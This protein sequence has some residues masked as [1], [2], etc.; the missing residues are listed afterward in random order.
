MSEHGKIQSKFQRIESWSRG[1]GAVKLFAHGEVTAIRRVVLVVEFVADQLGAQFR[2][3]T[4]ALKRLDDRLSQRVEASLTRG[5]VL[6][7]LFQMAPEGFRDPVALPILRV[8]LGGGKQAL[9][10][11]GTKPVDP[12]P[13]AQRQQVWVDWHGPKA[14]FGLDLLVLAF[15]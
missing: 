6:S 9:S 3:H 13:E 15:V 8:R 11:S 10:V 7:H 4:R 12:L 5:P 2:R 1:A 14:D